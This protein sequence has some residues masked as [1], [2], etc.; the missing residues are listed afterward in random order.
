MKLSD[1]EKQ[2]LVKLYFDGASVTDICLQHSLSKSTF[3]S[4]VKLHKTAP[5]NTGHVASVAELTK[6]KKRIGYLENK[7][8]VLQTVGC[9]VSASLSEKLR[10]LAMLHPSSKSCKS[11]ATTPKVFFLGL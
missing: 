10:E 3:Y 4:W 2:E 11:F 8:S 1:K 6:L 5:T 9:T 7:V